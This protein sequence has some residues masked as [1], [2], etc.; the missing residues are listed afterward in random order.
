M[1]KLKIAIYNNHKE[2]EIEGYRIEPGT[3][4]TGK[5]CFDDGAFYR[6]SDR[7]IMFDTD[8]GGSY[9]L[10]VIVKNYQERNA[11]LI[12]TIP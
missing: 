3:F 10:G 8:G 7:I 9:G 1:S 4:F 12:L 11:E 5:I 6:C 2:V